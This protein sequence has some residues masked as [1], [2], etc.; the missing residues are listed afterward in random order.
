M[1]NLMTRA[2]LNAPLTPWERSLLRLI[3]TCIYAGLITGLSGLTL[4]IVAL[5]HAP[6]TTQDLQVAGV[7]IVG[8]FL[9]G[10][11]AALGKFLLAQKLSPLAQAAAPVVAQVQQ[12]VQQSV[13]TATQSL[14]RNDVV[15]PAGATPHG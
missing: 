12:A 4:A 5:A 14:E 11:L 6:V 13:T 15:V 3:E 7:L 2:H 10:V 8:S 9:G 1:L